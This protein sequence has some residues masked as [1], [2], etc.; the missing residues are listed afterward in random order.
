MI[1]TIDHEEITAILKRGVRQE[2]RHVE[3]GEQRTMLAIQ[4]KP[5]LKRRLLGQI[6][7]TLFAVR[8]LESYMR[9]T[10]PMDHPVM[11]QLPDFVRHSVAMAEL[12]ANRMGLTTD[13]KGGDHIESLPMSEKMRL[14]GEAYGGK[15][16]ESALKKPFKLLGLL[17]PPRLTETY[18]DDPAVKRKLV[19]PQTD[20]DVG[21]PPPPVSGTSAA[22]PRALN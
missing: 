20:A 2:E 21:V 8:R 1:D 13:L 16:L 9:R 5:W 19:P 15:A 11:S 3:F 22:R 10:L 12:R 17:K 6:I 7:V 14:V 18:L 4:G